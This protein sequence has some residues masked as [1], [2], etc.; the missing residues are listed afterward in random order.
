LSPSAP[1][2]LRQGA[3]E[4]KLTAVHASAAYRHGRDASRQSSTGDGPL[5]PGA[6]GSGDYIERRREEGRNDWLIEEVLG[7]SF[8]DRPIQSKLVFPQT[9]SFERRPISENAMNVALRR[10]GYTKE[11]SHGF[12]ASASTILKENRFRHDVIAAQ[13]A[14][15]ESNE[16]R[17]AYH[18][19][20]IWAERVE[21]MRG[22]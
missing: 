17:R 9:R 7:Q 19:A 3:V 15:I 6:T 13:L 21:M 4:A 11:E 20:K 2:E 10:M 18:R 1:H 12:R 16:I 8:V 22:G 5:L 14:H